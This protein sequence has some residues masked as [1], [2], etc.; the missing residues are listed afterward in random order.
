MKE[1]EI[2]RALYS[3]ANIQTDDCYFDAKEGRIYTTDTICEGTHFR[4]DWSGPSE[5]ARKLVE[6][7]VSDIAA[8]GG[9]PTKAFFNFGLSPSCSGQE[10]LLPFAV[11]LQSRLSSYGILLCGGDT[12]RSPT[13]NLTLTLVGTANSPWKRSGGK[14]GEYLY[15]SGTVGLSRLGYKILGRSVE[16]PEPIRNK[17]LERHLTPTARLEL[18]SEL[19]KKFRISA[20][21]DLTDGLLQD[22][23]KLAASSE[24]GLRIDLKSVPVPKDVSPFLL[25]EEALGSGEELELLFLSPDILPN[26]LDEIPITKI[27]EAVDRASGVIFLE[28]GDERSFSD[29]GFE[30]F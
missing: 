24:V 10:W 1:S 26:T 6:V 4:L 11:S 14:K 5:I 7:N 16:V 18:A 15:L 12:Y 30:H 8:A 22:L 17:A 29:L 9:V 25:L 20:C 2:I 28:A 19:R 23:P 13:L 3:T 21:M 27:G